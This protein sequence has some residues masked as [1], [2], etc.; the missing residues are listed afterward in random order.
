MEVRKLVGTVEHY[1]SRISVAVVSLV[2]ELKLGDEIVIEG[3]TTSIKQKVESMQI[4]KKPVS[5][6]KPGDKIGLR[7]EGKVREGDKVYKEIV[8]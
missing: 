5:I 8:S 2:D 7:V 6:A 1:F 4:E 3:K